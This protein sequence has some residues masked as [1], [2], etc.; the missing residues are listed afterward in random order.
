MPPDIV[1][2]LT[3]L[4]KIGL[5]G[6][7]NVVA[8]LSPKTGS[9][10]LS[11][12]LPLGFSHPFEGELT[13]SHSIHEKPTYVQFA[14]MI[15][16]GSLRFAHECSNAA[17]S[18]RQHVNR[19]ISK[20]YAAPEYRF[21]TLVRSP[22][23]RLLS[24]WSHRPQR[25][26]LTDWSL[27]EQFIRSIPQRNFQLSFLAGKRFRGQQLLPGVAPC[28]LTVYAIPPVSTC[29]HACTLWILNT[30]AYE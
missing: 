29:F 25:G 22:L 15:K 2:T 26:N 28:R 5:P 4:T 20:L 7:D 8:L 18:R 6:S 3:C 13:C 17:V 30:L 10:N 23:E 24:E 16:A 27:L 11:V 21:I 1:Q 12:H 19:L 9:R 14:A